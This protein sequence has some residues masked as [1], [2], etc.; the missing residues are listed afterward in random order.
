MAVKTYLKAG[1]IHRQSLDDFLKEVEILNNLRHPNVVLYMG[2]CIQINRYSLVTEYLEEGSLF[3]Q[4]HKKHTILSTDRIFEIVEDIVMGMVYL[5]AKNILHRD[6]KSSNV[7]IGDDWKV[8]LCDFGLSEM[9]SKKKMKVGRAR[10]GTYQ[11][12]APEVLRKEKNI[13][14]SADVYSFGMVL[15]ELLTHKIPFEDNMP[16]QIE[17]LVGWDESFRVPTPT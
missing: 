13:G 7:L 11:W 14:F 16:A 6:L 3:D 1:R 17:G 12:M 10:I 5:H 15:W 4:L 8:K 9:H 2:M